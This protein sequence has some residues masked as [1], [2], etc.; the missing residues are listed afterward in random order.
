MKLL[1]PELSPQSP[2]W[3]PR[4]R[5]YELKHFCLQYPTWRKAYEHLNAL[6]ARPYDIEAIQKSGVS[7]P[8]AKI[9]TSKAYFSARTRMVFETAEELVFSTLSR[10]SLPMTSS[11][12]GTRFPAPARNTTS[13]TGSSSG[14]STRNGGDARNLHALL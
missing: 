3:I 5:Y 12:P 6:S 14:F 8:T 4:H 10:K 11:K 9:A 13:S 7:D 2:Y 1:T